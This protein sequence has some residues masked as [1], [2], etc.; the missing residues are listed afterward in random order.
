[1]DVIDSPWVGWPFF[2]FLFLS[3]VFTDS[4]LSV[5]GCFAAAVRVSTAENREKKNTHT[6][7][8][9]G[10]ILAAALIRSGLACMQENS[11]TTHRSLR[12]APLLS[13]PMPSA[14][15]LLGWTLLSLDI[16]TVGPQSAACCLWA[17]ALVDWTVLL[18]SQRL[19]GRHTI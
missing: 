16:C 5:C 7:T 8:T 2:L 10:L 13:T 18:Q 4:C 19:H 14:P 17:C 11:F 9:R 6:H 15:R 12:S 1:M 3:C